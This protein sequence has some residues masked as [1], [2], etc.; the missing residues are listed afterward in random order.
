MFKNIAGQK[1]AIYAWNAAE[2]T[3]KCNDAANIRAKI[4]KDG[5]AS[6][7]TNDVNPT[8]LDQALPNNITAITKAN[9]GVVSCVSH[10]LSIGDRVFFSGLS[11]MVE[12]NDTIQIVS[13]VG[14]ADLFSINNTSSYIAAETTGGAVG[15]KADHPGIYVF[16]LTQSETNADLII[17]SPY[18]ASQDV[19]ISPWIITP[20][21]VVAAPALASS[22][23]TTDGKIDNIK[24]KTDQLT[25]TV[26][27]IADANITYVNE[28]AVGGSGTGGDPWGPV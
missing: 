2:G 23:S 25:F 17:F 1:I 15:W 3:P 7:A 12:L 19:V 20:T 10:G 24:T 13:A 5:G 16:D 9:P 26:S 6:V 11:Q 27:G 22:L 18:S 4:S 14:S 28:I 21:L 8:Q